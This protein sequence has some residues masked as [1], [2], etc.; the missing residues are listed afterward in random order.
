M[1][2][3][4]R[5]PADG[6]EGFVEFEV[7]DEV[8]DGYHTFGELYRHRTTLL[9]ALCNSHPERAYKARHHDDGSMFD[10]MFIV[11]LHTDDG[12]ASYHC[13]DEFWDLFDIEEREA[14]EPFDGHTPDDVIQR[15]DSTNWSGKAMNTDWGAVDSI[16]ESAPAKNNWRKL[17]KEF[18]ESDEQIISRDFED[19][20]KARSARGCL[21]NDYPFL[22]KIGVKVS[23]RGTRVYLE[24]CDNPYPDYRPVAE[25]LAEES[26]PKKT[27]KS[28]DSATERKRAQMKSALKAAYK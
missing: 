11:V 18:A 28:A 9:A 22:Q 2:K 5:I 14:A 17:L 24:K 7:N 15:I 12:P 19:K 13:D 1:S 10:D 4:Y 8:S 26:E 25:L 27:A 21:T 23:S 16:P 20:K 3:T 6:T